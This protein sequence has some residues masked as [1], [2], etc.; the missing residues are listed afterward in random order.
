MTQNKRGR[1]RPAILDKDNY[2]RA[3]FIVNKEQ[4]ESIKEIAFREKKHIKDILEE[5]LG[6]YISKHPEEDGGMTLNE[7]QMKAMSTCMPTSEN[8]AYMFMNLVGELG[9]FASKV[10]K[11]I[12][13]DQMFIGGESAIYRNT[14]RCAENTRK[15]TAVLKEELLLEASDCLW[16][17]S[18]LCYVMGW[19]LDHVAQANLN[20]LASR[21]KRGVIDGNGDHR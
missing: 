11:A 10:A 17:L 1:G 9:E 12:R 20:K 18:G 2:T 7:Y 16:Q 3:T 5:A 21:A 19:G 13:K 8:F 14:L 4:I 6:N 15:E